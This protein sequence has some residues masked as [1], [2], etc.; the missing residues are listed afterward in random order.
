[1][2]RGWVEHERPA[3]NEKFTSLAFHFMYATKSKDCFRLNNLAINQHIN[4]FEGTKSLTTKSGLTHNMKNLIWKHT[5]D[6][7]T[8]F[9]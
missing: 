5:I 3:D 2:K 8:S 7:D 4:H 1:M 9:P 6:I